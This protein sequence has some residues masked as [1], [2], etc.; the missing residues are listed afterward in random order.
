MLF[1][2]VEIEI[3]FRRTTGSA[4]DIILAV[5]W[6]P[7]AQTVN[8]AVKHTERRRYQYRVMDLPVNSSLLSGIGDI[9]RQHGLAALLYFSRDG[10]QCLHLFRDRGRHGVPLDGIDKLHIALH[11]ML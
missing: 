3:S 5:L 9:F 2:W 1:I 11:I 10:Q 7:G 8:I 4:I 6:R